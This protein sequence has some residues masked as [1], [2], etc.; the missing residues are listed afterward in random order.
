MILIS[1]RYDPKEKHNLYLDSP[2]E[3]HNEAKIEHISVGCEAEKWVGEQA[4]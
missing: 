1:F 4:S 3:P 2:L